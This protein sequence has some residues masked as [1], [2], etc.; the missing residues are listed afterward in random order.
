MSVDSGE[1]ENEDVFEWVPHDSEQAMVR[2]RR[3]VVL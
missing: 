3:F 1:K 2:M